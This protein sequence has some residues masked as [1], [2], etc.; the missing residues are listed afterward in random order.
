MI[1]LVN[2]SLCLYSWHTLFVSCL[3]EYCCCC[4]SRGKS[5]PTAHLLSLT[6]AWLL[7]AADELPKTKAYVSMSLTSGTKKPFGR[8]PLKYTPTRLGPQACR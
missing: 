1:T 6:S 7:A 4:C 3:T 2:L 5:A 8:E